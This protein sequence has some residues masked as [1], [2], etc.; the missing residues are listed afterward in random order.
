MKFDGKALFQRKKKLILSVTAGVTAVT[1]GCGIW[2]Y[3]GHNR[4]DPVYVYPFSY[5]GMTEYW[6][7]SQE[8]YGPVTTDKI[9]TVFLS[10]TQTVTEIL[11]QEG[12]SVKKGD[13]LMTFDTTLSD[14]QL[15]RKRLDVEKLKLQLED[16][17]K[18]L[19]KINSMKPME[20]PSYTEEPETNTNT[21]T[22]VTKRVYPELNTAESAVYDGS[23]TQK[24][25]I[26]WVEPGKKVDEIDFTGVD[27]RI[28]E[29]QK[30]NAS[31]PTD[32]TT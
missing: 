20:I 7:D 14:L 12:D 10:D 28:A 21:G 22:K 27:Q 32:P 26:Y 4:A 19:K 2:Y 31:P 1:L 30:Q 29:I 25:V 15:E 8:S 9:Q 5:I 16:A 17:Q 6:G 13:L 18:E 3:V 11:V 23:S 24:A